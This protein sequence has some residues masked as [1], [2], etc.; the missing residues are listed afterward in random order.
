MESGPASRKKGGGGGA[1]TSFRDPGDVLVAPGVAA[2]FTFNW[3]E[4]IT[5]A[6]LEWELFRSNTNAKPRMIMPITIQSPF[7]VLEGPSFS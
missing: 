3:G 7:S 6:E 5:L 1:E 4:E 2:F